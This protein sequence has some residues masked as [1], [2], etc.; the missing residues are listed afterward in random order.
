M[1]DTRPLIR[2]VAFGE[3]TNALSSAKSISVK[4]T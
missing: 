2:S 4:K 3:K 1:F